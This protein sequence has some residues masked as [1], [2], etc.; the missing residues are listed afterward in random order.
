LVFLK[1][2]GERHV[3]QDERDHSLFLLKSRRNEIR[4]YHA[5]GY[6]RRRGRWVTE[7]AGR[8]GLL[9]A[10]RK[11]GED[12]RAKKP[13]TLKAE[14]AQRAWAYDAMVCYARARA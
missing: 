1:W 6:R 10:K 13:Q 5:L 9:L 4:R 12:T 8:K 7:G 11:L 2:R 14:A 3:D